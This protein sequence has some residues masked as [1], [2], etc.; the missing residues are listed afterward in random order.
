MKIFALIIPILIIFNSPDC[1]PARNKKAR[2]DETINKNIS[3]TPEKAATE[4]PIEQ[5]SRDEVKILAESQYSKVET[6]FIFVARSAETY[7]QLQNL[8]ENLPPA[9]EIDFTKSAIVAAFAGAKNTGGYSVSIKNAANKISISI[10]NPPKDAMLA[11]V[12]TAPFAVALVSP[13]ENDSLDLNVANEWKNAAR[14]YKITSASFTESGGF[15]GIQKNFDAEGAIGVWNFG[16]LATLA[17]DLAGKGA[18]KTRKLTTTASGTIKS[19]KIDLPSLD[20]GS[21]AQNPK[22]PLKVSGTLAGN[23]LSLVFEPLPTRV[24]DGFQASGKLE[25]ERSN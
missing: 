9:S 21:F 1:S 16:D 2:P 15:A 19:G 22:P 6:P 7:A 12:L 25:A 4:Q 20:A 3:K 11:Q 17:F 14:N 5:S 10:V 18:E 8:A 13:G 24:A 23:K